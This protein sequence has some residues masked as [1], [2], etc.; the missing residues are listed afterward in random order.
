MACRRARRPAGQGGADVSSRDWLFIG[1]E[2]CGAEA[3]DYFLPL[4]AS[5]YQGCKRRPTKYCDHPSFGRLL[6]LALGMAPGAYG[7]GTP[8]I[9]APGLSTSSGRRIARGRGSFFERWKPGDQSDDYVRIARQVIGYI[10]FGVARAHRDALQ[11]ISADDICDR[12][13]RE[14]PR[15]V[16]CQPREGCESRRQTSLCAF[17]G[18]GLGEGVAPCRSQPGP[19]DAAAS[20]EDAAPNSSSFGSLLPMAASQERIGEGP[21]LT[22]VL[23]PACS[24]AG[25]PPVRAYWISITSHRRFRRALLARGKRLVGRC[26]TRRQM[27]SALAFG[28]GG[29]GEGQVQSPRG[30]GRER[31]QHHLVQMMRLRR[32]LGGSKHT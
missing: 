14:I 7:S 24:E 13:L 19:I 8:L 26:P 31:R 9:E 22:E 11:D 4:P 20:Q 3:M 29:G 32:P 6:L 5:D 25:A 2:L 1:Y 23:Q 30:R 17:H 15:R 18:G 10:Q 28:G 21:S 27:Q 16:G 12:R